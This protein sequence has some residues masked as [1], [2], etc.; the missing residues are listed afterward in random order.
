MFRDV[1]DT[2]INPDVM[3]A[4]SVICGGPKDSQHE[5]YLV[6][7][8]GNKTAVAL[9]D[10][11]TFSLVSSWVNVENVNYLS[12]SECRDLVKE[13]SNKLQWTFTDFFMATRGMKAT[14]FKNVDAR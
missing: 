6:V 5:N 2:G 10:N 12:S 7:A 13:V 8:N 4:G 1:P 3:G 9:V 14:P 11:M